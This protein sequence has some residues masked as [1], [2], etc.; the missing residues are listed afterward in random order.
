MVDQVL[1]SCYASCHHDLSHIVMAPMQ[2]FPRIIEWAFGEDYEST[3]YVNIIKYLGKL[4][5]SGEY[6][7]KQINSIG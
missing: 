7:W 6:V 3:A 5:P 2:L 1:T 4:V